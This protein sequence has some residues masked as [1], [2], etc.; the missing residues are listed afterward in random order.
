MP[1]C[2]RLAASKRWPSLAAVPNAVYAVDVDNGSLVWQKNL[3]WSSD[4]PQEPRAGRTASFVTTRLTATPVVTPAGA[5]QRF[6]YVLANDGYLHTM[7]PATGDETDAPIQM[8]PE[9][10]R[11]SAT[12]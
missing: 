9:S 6:V 7:D 11:Q 3:K 5:G 2:I 10:L 1:E 8:V 4:Q 12:V